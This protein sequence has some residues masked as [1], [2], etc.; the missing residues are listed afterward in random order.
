MGIGEHPE[1]SACTAEPAA[2]FI[3]R[4]LAE[5][6]D[7]AYRDFMAKLIPTVD[8]ARILGVRTPE[9]R[10]IAKE[11]RRLPDVDEYLRALPHETFEE[12][13]VHA[14]AVGLEDDYDRAV[15]LYDAFLPHVD[16]W[17]TCDQMPVVTLAKKPDETLSH[18]DRW[19][20]SGHPYAMRFAIG[21]LMRLYLDER[22]D[23]GL[24]R[25]VADSRLPE[26]AALPAPESDAYYVDMMRAWYFAEAL[27]KQE[28]SILPYL[29][30]K[31]ADALLDEWTRRKAIQKA[32]ESR[33][34]SVALKEQLRSFR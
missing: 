26:A 18:I 34:V 22:F 1:Q 24:A 9:L 8:R 25:K 19:L 5:H 27:V 28:T 30:R 14:F 3:Q 23:A 21:V 7:P 20:A 15:A 6:I 4:A 17:A 33:R 16:N 10:R 31:G 2:A 12:N 11:L 13:Q 32:I 29:K